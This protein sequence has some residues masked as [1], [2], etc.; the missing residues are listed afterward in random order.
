MN[1]YF[2]F[3]GDA[4]DDGFAGAERKGSRW[5]KMRECQAFYQLF[6][7]T[8]DATRLYHY[9]KTYFDIFKTMSAIIKSSSHSTIGDKVEEIYHWSWLR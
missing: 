7:S 8:P 3:H 5:R 6:N 4:G 1:N 2:N 9:C